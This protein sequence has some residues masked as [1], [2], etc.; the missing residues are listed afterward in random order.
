MSR[1]PLNPR[2]QKEPIIRDICRNCNG[3]CIESHSDQ[4]VTR[5]CP[6]CDATGVAARPMSF[7]ERIK[8]L[9]AALEL[10]LDRGTK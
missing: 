6:Q 10:P 4:N 3:T 8:A 5:A 1:Q 2:L 9:E 7:S